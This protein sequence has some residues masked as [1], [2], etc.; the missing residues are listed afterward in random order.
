LRRVSFVLLE[1][2]MDDFV[3][4]P[5]RGRS[6]P[7]EGS[8]RALRRR[9]LADLQPLVKQGKY[10]LGSHAVRHAACEGFTERDIVA[11]VMFGRE[12]VR[13]PHDERLLVLGWLP[14][15]RAV[16]IPLHVVL[17]YRKPRWVDVVT[18]FIPA[19]P[20]RAVSRSR[21]AEILR[22]DRHVPE[23]TVVGPSDGGAV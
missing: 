20:H 1:A 13:Y 8:R 7:Y 11:T 21:L 3:G 5:A 22:H 18:A 6:T 10:R 9:D 2:T 19:D 23:R 4:N 14:V 17:E 15:S 16:K 12:L